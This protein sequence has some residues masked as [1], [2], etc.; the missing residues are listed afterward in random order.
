MQEIAELLRNRYKQVASHARV[1]GLAD[2]EDLLGSA[3][4][5]EANFSIALTKFEFHHAGARLE[6]AVSG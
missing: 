5:G 2:A 6:K 3:H 4:A 1:L